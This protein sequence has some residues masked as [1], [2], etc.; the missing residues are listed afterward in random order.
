MKPIKNV[1]GNSIVPRS[2]KIAV[3]C[4]LV[5]HSFFAAAQPLEPPVITMIDGQPV[6]P[7][8]SPG[9]SAVVPLSWNDPAFA[10]ATS[11]GRLV[12]S[13]GQS[14][15]NLSI[16]EQSGE[17]SIICNGSC[18]L[19]RIRIQSREGYRCVSG[20]QNLSWMWIEAT[21][22]GSDHAD[23]IQCYSPGS[24]GTLTVKNTTIKV[25]G[26]MNAAYFAADDWNGSHVLENVLLWGGQSCFF[27]PGDGGSSVSLTNVYI[28]QN[29]CRTPFRYDTVNGRRATIVKWE[30]VRYVSIQNGQ[31]VMGA[32]I[33]RP[34]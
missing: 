20:S 14:R 8:P 19:A 24:G 13:S 4:V 26:E 16:A 5:A 27:V 9:S 30:N 21:G 6:A 34:Y 29:S 2:L 12:L 22:I 32:S 33:P 31:L 25:S 23:G 7:S 1:V 3:G 11:S 17:P 18:T 15:S 28:M 10:S